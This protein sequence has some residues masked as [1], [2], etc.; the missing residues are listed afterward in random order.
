MKSSLS[1]KSKDK[2]L[3]YIRNSS[4]IDFNFPHKNGLGIS[5]FLSHVSSECQDLITKLLAYNPEERFS[6][7]QA[8][9]HPYFKD[10]V[11]QEIKLSKMSSNNFNKQNLMISFQNDS[12][13]FIKG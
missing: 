10:L 5:K 9:N 7:K 4:H 1:L 6:S 3:I 8:L 2:K 13:S 11:E 12:I